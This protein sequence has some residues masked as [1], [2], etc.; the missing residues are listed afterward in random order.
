MSNNPT[1]SLIVKLLL[2]VV[3]M[4]CFGFALVPLYNV[5]CQVTGINGKPSSTA[6]Q[7]EEVKVD[8]SRTITVQFA[9]ANNAGMQWK[10]EPNQVKVTLH[11]GESKNVSY[12][13]KNPADHAI[14]AQAIPSIAPGRAAAYVHKT[15][16]F[17]FSQQTL[18][19]GESRDM[20]I[21]FFIDQDVPKDVHTI[22]LTY[23]IFD[24][25]DKA[26]KKVASVK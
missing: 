18:A 17:C 2:A 14:T 21:R 9:A 25:T 12:F 3:G 1:N 24:V 22:T 10:F 15:Q 11:P 5:F 7:A 4:F 13:A 19:A 16:C 23:T 8:T 6:Y 20:P 26:E